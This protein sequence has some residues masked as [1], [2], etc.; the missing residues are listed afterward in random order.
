MLLQPGCRRSGACV[1]TAEKKKIDW[2]TV[3][4]V[5]VVLIAVIAVA[6]ALI[7]IWAQD[8]RWIATAGV[9]LFVDGVVTFIASEL[10]D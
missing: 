3:T 8:W 9:L 4:I 1:K 2:E 5:F 7:S 10:F 6:C